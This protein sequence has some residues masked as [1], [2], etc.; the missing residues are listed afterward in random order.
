[1]ADAPQP[2]WR[3]APKI[4][5]ATVDNIGPGRLPSSSHTLTHKFKRSCAVLPDQLP[6]L[7]DRITAG[8]RKPMGTA[9][10]LVTKDNDT[11]SISQGT[12]PAHRAACLATPQTWTDSTRRLLRSER[13][14]LRPITRSTVTK[15][16]IESSR[17]G[18]V[19]SAQGLPM[20]AYCV[21]LLATDGSVSHA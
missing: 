7:H 10:D 17:S 13:I 19:V 2:L 21:S 18:A 8:A 5:S 3:I 11:I 9:G 1:M 16:A 15:A 14:A 20:H 12:S 4:V 6:D